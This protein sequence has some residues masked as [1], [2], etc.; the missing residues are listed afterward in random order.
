MAKDLYNACFSRNLGIITAQEQ[1]RLSQCTVAIAGMGG[2]GS[3]T[4]IMLARMGVSRFR[5]ADFDTFEHANLNRQYGAFLDTIGR[6]KVDVMAEEIRRINPLAQVTVYREG[7]K[8]ENAGD[9]LDGVDIVVDS[10]DFYSIETHLAFHRAARQ[11]NLY[12]LMG[13]PVG[14]SGCLQVFDPEGM[15]LEE[16]CGIE[17]GM[18]AIEKQLRYACGVVPNLAHID[19]FDVSLSSSN[20]NFLKKTGPSLASA[21]VLAASLVASEVVILLLKRRKPRAIPYSFQFDPYTYR[22]EK[23]W[24]EN[25]MRDYDADRALSRISDRGSLIPLVLKYLYKRKKTKRAKINGAQI[26]YESHGTGENLL[27]I[28]PLGADSSFWSRQTQELAKHFRVI[29]FDSRG[30][31]FS[32][33]CDQNCSTQQAAED[34]AALLKHL[35]VRRTHVVGLALGGLIAQVLGANHPELVDHLVLA[36]SYAKADGPMCELIRRWQTIA[37]TQGMEELFDACLPY[38]FSTDYVADTNGELDQLRTFFHL[39]LQ[40]SQSFVYQS[41][42]GI[43]HDSTLRLA[44]IRCPTL[45]LHG[46]E[47][48]VVS[49]TLAVELAAGIRDCKLALIKGAPHFMSW[50]NSAAFSQEI[51]QFL[52]SERTT[53]EI[54]SRLSISA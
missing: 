15:G 19:Y 28:S 2:I 21:T 27:L 4:A 54:P 30:A 50:E 12:I 14:F 33:S 52:E 20:T 53:L 16:Y 42:S 1:Q 29:T 47:D 22:Y 5:I 40:D 35:G 25:G 51:V 9:L 43:R 23:A 36:S 49:R 45:V 17:P 48:R 6:A 41:D 26:Y 24:L 34:A 44:A 32:S 8:P 7:F 13:S 31:G 39:N 11:R 3:N 46:E 10:I 37:V 18:L 38:L